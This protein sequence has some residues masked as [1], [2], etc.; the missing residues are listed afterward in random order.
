MARFFGPLILLIA[1]AASGDEDR[2]AAL[3]ALL[4]RARTLAAARPGDA[5]LLQLARDIDAFERAWVEA[6]V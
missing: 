6:V 1:V 3:R 5:A 2:A 4:Q